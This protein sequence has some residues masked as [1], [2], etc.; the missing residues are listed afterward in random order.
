MVGR[1]CSEGLLTTLWAR[2]VQHL[3][4]LACPEAWVPS[5]WRRASVPLTPS[6]LRCWARCQ[7]RPPAGPGSHAS[8]RSTTSAAAR[9]IPL[10]APRRLRRIA[11]MRVVA[12]RWRPTQERE[13]GGSIREPEFSIK[14]AISRRIRLHSRSAQPEQQS[15]DPPTNHI[16]VQ[17]ARCQRSRF[18]RSR[19]AGLGPGSRASGAFAGAV[20]DRPLTRDRCASSG[21]RSRR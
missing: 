21:P 6:P 1:Q 9:A 7:D 13:G 5:G 16:M 12:L 15:C 2:S 4:A 14:R 10:A 3:G 20:R 18:C 8:L 19:S 17:R 11:T